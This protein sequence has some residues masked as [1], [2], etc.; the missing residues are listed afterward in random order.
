MSDDKA[1]RLSKYMS[2]L[3]L[4]SRRE[5]DQYISQGQVKVD[6]KIVEQLGFK[7]IPPVEVEL[8]GQAKSQQD[9]K[10]SVILYKPIGY[11]SGPKE[12]EYPSALDL[13]QEKN[14]RPLTKQNRLKSHLKHGMAPVG[15]LDVDTTGLLI[16]SSY[17]PLVKKIIGPD[18]NVEKEYIVK[19]KTVP[20][21]EQIQNLSN[22][23]ITLDDQKLLPCKCYFEQK[24]QKLH[25]ILK[26]GK[27]RQ[28]RRMCEAVDLEVI[29]LK[30][31]R[32]GPLTL[33]GL[34]SGEWRYIDRKEIDQI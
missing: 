32:I 28:V 23:S 29:A 24:S 8:V 4:C 25:L 14:R 6:G 2:E 11:V 17:G 26:E 15:R 34:K 30:R 5:A 3:G 12:R 31:I 19:V 9:E 20:T 10:L 21:A 13:I 27:K 16:L 1:I 22:G 33:K 7:I 18:N